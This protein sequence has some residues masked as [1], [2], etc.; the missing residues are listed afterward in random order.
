MGAGQSSRRATP[1]I[2]RTVEEVY[3]ELYRDEFFIDTW[4]V[5]ESILFVL[6]LA[7]VYV[8]GF[9]LYTVAPSVMISTGWAHTV[10]HQGWWCIIEFV[11]IM[12]GWRVSKFVLPP[13]G[14]GR[15][16]FSLSRAKQW[17]VAHLVVLI[18]GG[19]A[20]I[21]DIVLTGLEFG[22]AESTCYFS[23]WGFLLAFLIVLCL[24]LLVIKL[25]L[26][27]FT[28]EYRRHLEAVRHTKDDGYSVKTQL[29]DVSPYESSATSAAAALER[30]KT[31]LLQQQQQ[32]KKGK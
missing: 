8:T 13:P 11:V 4:V 10:S 2:N 21:A 18:L 23:S 25:P 1:P 14:P 27:W 30:A 16:K 6:W 5:F 28:L 20:D 24:Q 22:D 26:A 3:A 32:M 12:I 17:C 31:P 15:L 9:A 19:I 7:M 29:F